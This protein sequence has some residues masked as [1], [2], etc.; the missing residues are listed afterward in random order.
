MAYQIAMMTAITWSKKSSEM[1]NRTLSDC[2]LL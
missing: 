1:A 2:Q